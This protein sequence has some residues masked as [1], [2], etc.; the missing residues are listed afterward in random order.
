M[1]AKITKN[2]I[3]PSIGRIQARFTTLP[4]QAYQFWRK[5]TPKKSGNARRRTRL[6]RDTIQARYPYA[7]RLDE[8]WSKQAPNGMFQPTVDYI[9]RITK[10]MLRK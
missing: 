7:K 3:T 5:T 6:D 2:Q 10:K 4:K 9:K 1:T 8:G